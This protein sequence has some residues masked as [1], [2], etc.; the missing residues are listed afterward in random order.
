MLGTVLLAFAFVFGCFASAGVANF[1]RVQLGW[2]ALTLL[3]GS[4]LFGRIL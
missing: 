3:I 4:M 2:L 1:G